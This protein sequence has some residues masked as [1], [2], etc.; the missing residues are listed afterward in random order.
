MPD[1]TLWSPKRVREYN[2]AL[3]ADSDAPHAVLNIEHL[4]IRVPV[5][6]GADEFNLNRGVARVK[7]TAHIGQSGN[8]GIAGHRDG[9][10]R[11]L[12][13]IKI[14]DTFELETY[15]GKTKYRVSSIDIV[16]PTELS[17]LAPTDTPMV[18]LVTCYPFYYVGHAP[19]RF[20]VKAEALFN[21]V[22]S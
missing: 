7:G 14:G 8:L 2:E 9:F 6:N 17:V 11:P 5:Y 21:Q 22:N 3:A 18:T 10:F 20:I 13:D 1:T 15:Y 4:N 12:K 19:Q 16:E